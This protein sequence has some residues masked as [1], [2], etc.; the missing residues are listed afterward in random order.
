MLRRLISFSLLVKLNRR[1]HSVSRFSLVLF[2]QDWIEYFT[3]FLDFSTKLIV[4]REFQFFYF[5]FFLWER[6]QWFC[7]LITDC[8]KN[9]LFSRFDDHNNFV[10]TRL[11]LAFYLGLWIE[12]ALLFWL[13]CSTSFCFSSTLSSKILSRSWSFFF[14]CVGRF[15]QRHVNMTFKVPARWIILYKLSHLG[16]KQKKAPVILHCTLNHSVFGSLSLHG[17][18]AHRN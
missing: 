2:L 5:V 13:N 12:I 1:I 7:R 18:N 4:S 16:L 10:Y 9:I 8:I 14:A 17:P 11:H 15:L 3:E 6:F